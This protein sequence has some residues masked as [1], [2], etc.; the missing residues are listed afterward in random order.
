MLSVARFIV[1]LAAVALVA[2]RSVEQ[3]SS[4]FGVAR[5]D[6]T[7]ISR[8]IQASNPNCKIHAFTPHL[9]RNEIYAYTNCKVF[10]A[11]KAQGRWKLI[12]K[13]VIVL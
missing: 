6:A 7:E 3:N 8:L 1:P 12:K 11:K 10:V 5:E 4:T 9:E 2:C 13:D